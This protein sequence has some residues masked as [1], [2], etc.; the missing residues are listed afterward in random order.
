M[1]PGARANVGTVSEALGSRIRAQRRLAGFTV[2]GLAGRTGLSPSLISQVERGR[3]T[4]SVATLWAVATERGLSVADLFNDEEPLAD[5]D[6][7]REAGG[8]PVQPYETRKAITLEGGVR[9]E[10]LT[11]SPDAG[12]DFVHVEYP[13]GAESCD[14]QALIRHGGREF[15]Y[16]LSGTLGIRIGFDEYVVRTNDSVSFDSSL[17]HRLWAIGDEPACAIWLV[18]NRRGEPRVT[19]P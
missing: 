12:V 17:P 6:D 3:A 18:L 1:E 15:G 13:P 4:P 9:W 2:R 16:V 14:E 8:P 11:A 19:F 7:R 5:D 10:R